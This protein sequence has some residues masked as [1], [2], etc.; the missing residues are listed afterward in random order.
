MAQ[1]LWDVLQAKFKSAKLKQNAKPQRKPLAW[2]IDEQFFA[3]QQV[4][5]DYIRQ[6]YRPQQTI[7][8]SRRWRG[9]KEVHIALGGGWSFTW[10]IAFVVIVSALFSLGAARLLAY[11]AESLAHYLALLPQ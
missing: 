2:P 8:E 4:E 11:P 9:W 6:S 5:L 10:R 3:E 7:A 1:T